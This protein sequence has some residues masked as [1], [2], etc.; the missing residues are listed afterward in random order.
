MVKTEFLD[1]IFNIADP[2]NVKSWTWAV[3]TKLCPVNGSRFVNFTNKMC[4]IKDD[5][6][7]NRHKTLRNPFWQNLD[8]AEILEYEIITFNFEKFLFP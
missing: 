4:V 5:M 2:S 3:F 1:K 8:S 6:N 7:L